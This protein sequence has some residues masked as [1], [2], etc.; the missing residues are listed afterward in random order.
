MRPVKIITTTYN[1]ELS[2]E[3]WEALE[4]NT[5]K[6]IE[7]LNS[8]EEEAA[9]NKSGNRCIGQT[10]KDTIAETKTYLEDI[11]EVITDES[12]GRS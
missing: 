3:E 2:K 7:I 8:I 5:N 10:L 9:I 4:L 6:L 1:L 11:R 12:Y